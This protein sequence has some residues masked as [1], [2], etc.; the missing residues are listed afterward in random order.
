MIGCPMFHS[1]VIKVDLLLQ[2]LVTQLVA[3]LLIVNV[4]IIK[5]F[6]WSYLMSVSVPTV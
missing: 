1:R 6:G 5:I 3:E 4:A 2:F